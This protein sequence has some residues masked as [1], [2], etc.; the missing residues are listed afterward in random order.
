M[1]FLLSS[2]GGMAYPSNQSGW[3]DNVN[4]SS[5]SECKDWVLVFED[6]FDGEA[7]NTDNWSRIAYDNNKYNNWRRYQSTDESLV[8]MTG[9]T[10]KLWGR[11]GNYTSQDN[12]SGIG[13][14]YACGGITSINTFKFQYGYVE[15]QARFDSTQGCWPAIWMMPKSNGPLGWPGNG[16]I[17]IMEHLN[18]D[19]FV[20]QTLHSYDSSRPD[21]DYSMSFQQ[22]W[23]NANYINDWHTYGMLWTE[24]SITFYVDGQATL[25]HT[26][27]SDDGPWP[28]DNEG[29]EFYLIIDQQIGGAWVEGEGTGGI[30]Q[31]TLAETGSA[32]E[33]N[34]VR[35][36][37][38]PSYMHVVP[39]PA[40][41]SLA[42]LGLLSFATRRR[43]DPLPQ[44]VENG[45]N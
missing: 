26:F 12:Q 23:M 37:S 40:S 18:N 8:E 38:T 13:Q 1:L 36:Y 16:E 6:E 31:D 2:M 35:V 41:A 10:V 9:D 5:R 44:V 20:Y 30:D 34:Y 39:E 29:N 28:F 17:D 42:L 22:K 32:M 7:L 21:N 14:T 15:V 24:G 3:N 45:R 4:L 43:R 33:I 11:Y 19:G 25:S 27:T